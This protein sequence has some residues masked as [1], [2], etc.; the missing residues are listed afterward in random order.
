MADYYNLNGQIISNAEA[1]INPNNRAFKFGDA[2]FETIRLINGF[3]QFLE[4]H[5]SRLTSGMLLLKMNVPVQFGVDFFTQQISLLALKKGIASDARVRVT[6]F[7]N[8]GGHYSPLNNDVSFLIEME[9]LEQQ[10]YAW[11]EKGYTID[12]YNEMRKNINPLSS[13][14]SANSL[15]YVLAGVFRKDKKLDECIV[16]NEK[17]NI[18]EAI[19]HNVFAVKNGVLYTPP[20]EEGCIDGIM[21]KQVIRLAIQNRIAVYEINL[22]Q[23]V[24]LSA[25]ELFLTNA[26]YGIRWV[27]NFRNKQYSNKTT[28]FLSEKLNAGIGITV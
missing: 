15:F 13:L 27:G 12:V 9:P 11:N 10:G 8:D 26:L 3:P 28:Q 21:R 4:H 2:L 25:D 24:L 7:R 18:V 16:L 1:V 14:K 5:L 19:S 17:F 20:L 23:N 22:A 6:V